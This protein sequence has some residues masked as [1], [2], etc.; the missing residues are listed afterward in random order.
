[1]KKFFLGVFL[2]FLALVSYFI[3]SNDQKK[4][5][6]VTEVS[7]PSVAENLDLYPFYNRLSS[8]EKLAY[9]KICQ[10]IDNFSASTSPIYKCSTFTSAE[11]FAEEIADIYREII[12][13]QSEVFWV[14]PYYCE[15]VINEYKD[16]YTVSI[17]PRYTIEKDNK[18]YMKGRLDQIL[19]DVT[20][21]ASAKST[22][23]EKILYVYDYIL[24]NCYYD[25]SIIEDDNFS[26]TDI[27]VYGCL[28]DGKTV[29]SGYT[30]A[31]DAI[32]KRLGFECGV[33]FNTYDDF[34]ILTG[35]VW[36][37]CKIEDEY[38]YFDLTWDDTGFD[39]EEYK[40]Y[41]DYSYMYFGITKDELS[42][43]NFTLSSD[44]KTPL[45]NGT[46]YNYFT[47]NGYSL[48]EYDYESA[49]EAMLKQTTENYVA[50]RF[51]SYSELLEA[52]TDLLTNGKIYSV[53]P[54]K[55]AIK[56]VISNSSL[57]LYILL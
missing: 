29:C 3:Y 9:K 32:M 37:Y 48:A 35:H 14:D 18:E 24:S 17:K 28:I 2:L 55:E 25:T 19:D 21:K 38:Y 54:D 31:F 49:K 33:E 26:S 50:L 45:C 1:M 51:D 13:E 5:M 12:F 27:N 40:Q 22:D 44:A 52:E 7:L 20:T 16:E 43:S 36:N 30:L 15:Y 57:Y 10:A 56:Y 42:K 6:E 8:D 46:K 34:S 11:N 23:F 53:Y 41:L 47:Y 39:S 4:D